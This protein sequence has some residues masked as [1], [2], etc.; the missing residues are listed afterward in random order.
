MYLNTYY[1]YVT[2]L[3]LHNYILGHGE[4]EKASSGGGGNRTR[5]HACQPPTL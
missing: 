1:L 5:T 4:G 3:D 2:M